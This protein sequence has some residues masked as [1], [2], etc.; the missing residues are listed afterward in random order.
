MK[1]QKN[2]CVRAMLIV[3][4]ASFL[5]PVLLTSCGLK[6]D[7]TINE[8]ESVVETTIQNESDITSEDQTL[9]V[10]KEIQNSY[11][12]MYYLAFTAENIRTS[13]N[14]RL[15]LDDT[16]TALL[17]DINP[18]AIDERTQEHLSNLRDIIKSYLNVNTK[19]ERLQYIYNQNKAAAMR[20]AVPNPVAILS[21]ANSID[22][23]RLAVATVYTVVD[24]YNSYK[25]AS[26]SADMEYIMSG[27]DLDDEELAAVQKNRDRAFDYMVDMVQ[28]YDLDGLKTFNEKD[29]ATYTEIC[30]IESPTEKI[31]R[32]KAEEEKYELFGNYWL[33]LANCYFETDKYSECLECVSRYDKLYTGIY[34]KDA[35]YV[36]ILPK[37]IVAAQNT[38]SGDEY[39]EHVGRFADSIIANTETKDW[40]T[41]YFAAQVYLD[42]Y[43]KS[44]QNSDYLDKAYEIIYENVS[45]LLSEQ[46]SIN[47]KYVNAVQE[48]KIKE[49]DY[50]KM[51][52]DE[53]KKKKQEYKDEKERVKKYNKELK[54]ARKTE[55][56]ELYEPLVLNCDLLFALAEKKGISQTE[57]DDIDALLQ[58]STNGIFCVAPINNAYSFSDNSVTVGATLK[59]DEIY[60]PVVLLTKESEI[61]IVIT[62]G[63]KT[64]VIDDYKISEVKRKG[65]SS[66]NDFTAKI[67]SKKW[68]KYKWTKNS[69]INIT[70]TYKDAYDKT[71]SM[72]YKVKAIKK[73]WNGKKV[74]FE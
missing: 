26:E 52:A 60:I 28:Q 25:S 24:S 13:K 20:N 9:E 42:L 1:K 46:R 16:Y 31:V 64:T 43:T 19:R 71:Y 12:M 10:D 14:N 49:P 6:K 54:N 72:D 21:M 38:Y 50:S 8:N 61:S 66:I 39:I 51:S 7:A 74:E 33:E 40:S 68:K 15:V 58:S 3:V 67:T 41:R 4:V 45:V 5:S 32:L 34:R 62:D 11:S 59:D 73:H 70:I 57:K 22:W 56:P 29:V 63:D 30:Q 17:N 36:Q 35:N 2:V 53:K 65:S 37:A 44:N 69:S 23:K 47:D 55:L 18:G 48:E 27:W